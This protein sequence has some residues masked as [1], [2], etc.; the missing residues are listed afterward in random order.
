MS[1]VASWLVSEVTCQEGGSQ[2]ASLYSL[3]ATVA[4]QPA[5]KKRSDPVAGWLPF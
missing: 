1:D 3:L 5:S 2:R 4:L